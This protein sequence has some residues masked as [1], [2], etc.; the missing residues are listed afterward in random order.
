MFNDYPQG[1]QSFHLARSHSFTKQ[2][3][4]AKRSRWRTHSFEPLEERWTPSA[5]PGI[6]VSQPRNEN[7]LVVSGSLNATT[8]TIAPISSAVDQ[9]MSTYAING[10][11]FSYQF[12]ANENI[13]IDLSSGGNV[14]TVGKSGMAAM[15][16]PSV[17]II[18][19]SGTNNITVSNVIVSGAVTINDGSG[20]SV[21]Y[22]NS[23]TVIAST[24][25]SLRLN[26]Q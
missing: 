23:A 7:T 26:R 18:T 11:G 25:G 13:S 8:L 22:Q 10:N 20:L 21:P 5:T 14:I 2:S 16:F 19:A 24:V 4:A 9:L 15:S 17:S 1:P 3:R 12:P 6:T